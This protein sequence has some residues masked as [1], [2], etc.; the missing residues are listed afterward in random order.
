MHAQRILEEVLVR[1]LSAPM[2]KNK[3]MS[4]GGVKQVN[5][6]PFM[7]AYCPFLRCPSLGCSTLNL[8]LFHGTL[9]NLGIVHVVIACFCA[10]TR[11]AASGETDEA[12]PSIETP[13][14][15]AATNAKKQ[16][17]E[18][19]DGEHRGEGNVDQNATAPESTDGAEAVNQAYLKLL[20]DQ[21]I[22][23]QLARDALSTANNDYEGAQIWIL[24]RSEEQERSN[25]TA[26]DDPAGELR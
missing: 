23:E 11:T 18:P 9:T 22:E 2:P 7:H 10:G 20:L 19:T 1:P 26:S 8:V 13:P 6:R 4:D 15:G 14:V 25:N 24:T 3:R 16:R 21:G 5:H 12:N 17:K